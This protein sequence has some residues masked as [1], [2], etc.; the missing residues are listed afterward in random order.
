MAQFTRSTGMNTA[1]SERVIERIVNP[2]SPEPSSAARSGPRTCSKPQ[3][4]AP[5]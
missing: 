1:T 2:I 5:R 4:P 3:P